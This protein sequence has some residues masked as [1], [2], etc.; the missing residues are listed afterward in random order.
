MKSG[1]STVLT[2]AA[3]TNAS[4]DSFTFAYSTDNQQWVNMFTVSDSTSGE[5]QFSLPAGI[6]GTMYV[7]VKDN[8]RDLSEATSYSVRV[9]HLMI[10]SENGTGEALPLPSAPTNPSADTGGQD[11]IS[12]SWT[13]ASNNEAGF[14]VERRME[15]SAMATGGNRA[16][17]FHLFRGH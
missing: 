12:I 5:L 17:Q 14:T 8:V 6:N 1:K 10:R 13:D 15:G 7:R 16:G 2:A 9:D 11:S 4:T 3:T